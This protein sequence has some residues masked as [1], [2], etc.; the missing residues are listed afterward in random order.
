MDSF[1]LLRRRT[2]DLFNSLPQSLP[3]LPSLRGHGSNNMKGTWEKIQ[4]PPLPRSA[5]S[6][7]ILAGNLYIFGGEV[8]PGRPI[9][10]DMHVVTLPSSGAQGDYYAIKA[11]A[12]KARAP[13]EQLAAPTVEAGEASAP[14]EDTPDDRNLSDIPLT[15]PSPA[16]NKGKGIAPAS[17]PD[18]PAPRIGH[19]TAAIGHRIFLFGGRPG[20][21]QPPLNEAGRVWVFDTRTHLWSFLDPAPAPPHTTTTLTPPPRSA[22]SAAATP[23]PDTFTPAAATPHHHP[24]PHS[25]EAW[26][27]W[28]LGTENVAETGTPQRPVVGVLAAR[29]TDADADGFGT[30]LVHGGV[31]ADGT[32]ADDVWAFDVRSRTWQRLPDAPGPG[33]GLSSGGGGRLVLS[34]SR[35]YRYG[36]VEEGDGG[37]GGD[38][39]VGRLDF[40][41]LGVAV[42]DDQV[43]R[44]AEAMLCVRGG[45]GWQSL[46]QG[47]EDVGYKE[48]DNAATPVLQRAEER[49]P[50]RR[51][52]AGFEAVT[53]GRGREYLVLMFGEREEASSGAGRFWDDVWAFQAP[54][55]GMSLASVADTAF[56]AMG[57]KSGEGRWQKVEMGPFDDEDDASADGP[58]PRGWVATATMGDLEENGIVVWGGLGEGDQRLGDGWIL[59]LG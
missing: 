42:V 45:G 24:D 20:P 54:S 11:K 53:V 46:V 3:S 19:A 47:R 8:E 34:G 16:L 6:A 59:R 14:G 27:T 31:L 28:A 21:D 18:V 40:L 25:P 12:A 29:A 58:G 13:A 9:D 5:H 57:K 52:V 1:Q 26:R 35:L 41:E 44:G 38:D 30:L 23:K 2:T 10:N 22:H 55:D 43:T 48:V 17:L 7:D 49:W 36:G 39:G 15:T 32:R 51:T 4:V 50:G 37:D 56:S 33:A